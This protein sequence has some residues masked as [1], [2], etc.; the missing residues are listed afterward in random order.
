M[1]N[2]KKYEYKKV[3]LIAMATAIAIFL[4]FIILDNGIFI[5]FGDYN[6]QQIPFYKLAHEAIRSG[7]IAWNWHTDLGANFIGSYTFYLLG[8]PFFWLTLPFPTSMVPYLMGPLLILKFS[9][10]SLTAYAF[11]RRF[12]KTSSFAII[13]GI[14]FAF[15]GFNIYNVFFNHFN[16]SIVFFPLL[17][18]GL[19][20]SVINNKKGLFAISIAINAIVN[21][22]FFAGQV[23]FLIIYF[24][25]R[26]S[27][28]EFNVNFKKI[29]IL[30]FESIIGVAMAVFI[31]LPSAL[32]I[33]GNYRVSEFLT[34]WNFLLYNDVQRYP[35]IIHSLFFPP[36]IP[37]RPNF[38]PENNAKW[39]SIAAM[40]PLFTMTAVISFF[41]YTKKHW[42][43]TILIVCGIMAFIPGLNSMFYALNTSYYAR[44]FYMPIL[45]MALITTLSLEN[46][47]IDIRYGI[48][49]SLYVVLSFSIIGIIPVIKDNILK[50]GGLPPSSLKFWLSVMISLVSLYIVYILVTKYKKNSRMLFS[51]SLYS[52]CIITVIY[53]IIFIS[54]GKVHSFHERDII[55]KGLNAPKTLNLP[56]DEFYRIDI[57]N[58][59]DNWGMYWGMSNIQTFHSVV[60]PSIMEFYPE[61]GIERN[62]HSKPL[63]EQYGLRG[64]LSVKYILTEDKEENK[65]DTPGFSFLDTRAGFRIYKNDL[66][67]PMGFTYDY[68]I[69]KTMFENYPEKKRNLLL[70]KGIYLDG[71]EIKFPHLLKKLPNDIAQ[72][73]YPNDYMEDTK[74]RKK[75]SSYEFETNNKG[76]IS[77]INLDKENLVF[78]SVPFDKGWKAYVND[79]PTEI[80]K[81]NIGFMSVVA[82]KGDNKIVFEYKT[83]GLKIG[84]IISIIS[85]IIFIIYIVI[86]IKKKKKYKNKRS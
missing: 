20:E 62:V 36:D 15:C 70:M 56:E 45:I 59:M 37:S 61:L 54:S 82:P 32:A 17:L 73:S 12:S 9:F 72:N 10:S 78:F 64:L 53:S 31:L 51:L 11:I 81:S 65:V 83:P 19:E 40:L 41:K 21:Y 28:K 85:G 44:W 27:S 84:I 57:L 5:F 79:E 66:F 3:F 46:R 24:I 35:S 23:V 58:G 8:S 63:A 55:D 34:G 25:I 86:F 22:F 80:I 1:Y 6:V 49:F 30:A 43:K 42:T 60:P 7:N 13:G 2:I 68:Y 26:L 4:P 71:L 76:F 47:K 75:Q 74:D 77:K 16:E 52:I 18:I 69:D 14:M 67:L 38:F 50:W 48:K 33:S 29:L 39:S